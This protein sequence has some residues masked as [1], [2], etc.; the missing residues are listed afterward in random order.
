MKTLYTESSFTMIVLLNEMGLIDIVRAGRGEGR[1]VVREGRDGVGE[2]REELGRGE[3][4][5][6]K[7]RNGAGERS[8]GIGG[9]E[10]WGW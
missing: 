2:G 5:L 4:G 9:G 7:G 8:D 10:R 6:G 1:D 3:M